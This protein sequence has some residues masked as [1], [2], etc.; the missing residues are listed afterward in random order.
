MT[1]LICDAP[2]F[3][4]KYRCPVFQTRQLESSPST[5]T[6]KNSAS[7]RS[8]T[9]T[10]SSV[11]LETRGAGARARSADDVRRSSFDVR[12]SPFNVRGSTFGVRGSTVDGRRSTVVGRASAAGGTGSVAGSSS[13]GRSNRSVIGELRELLDVVRAQAQSFDV[14][15]AAGLLVGFDDDPIQPRVFGGGLDPR[16]QRRQES[17]ERGLG[18]DADD[19]I[20]RP[21]HADV[22]EIHGA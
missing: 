5:Q 3:S 4:V 19:R 9:R 20:V 15:G 18:V 14:G 12:R 22:G 21:G 6:S 1:P 10:V 2:S 8:L 11:T 16:R 13:N 7:S 17:A